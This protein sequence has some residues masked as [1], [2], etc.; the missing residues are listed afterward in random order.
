[1]EYEKEIKTERQAKIQNKMKF[2]TVLLNPKRTS[3]SERLSK[4]SLAIFRFE[5]KP[6][7]L[8]PKQNAYL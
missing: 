2:H 1:M 3:L 8:T 6:N 4:T 5:L 7:V